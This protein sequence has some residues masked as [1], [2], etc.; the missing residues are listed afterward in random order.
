MYIYNVIYAVIC[1]RCNMLYIQD[2][3]NK[4]SVRF[5]VHLR[6]IKREN[7]SV[8]NHFDA[9]G[10]KLEQRLLAHKLDEIAITVVTSAEENSGRQCHKCEHAPFRLRFT[11]FYTTPLYTQTSK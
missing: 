3:T 11:C 10:H 9:N 1:R 2:T 8:A 6:T 7:M 4:L 5:F